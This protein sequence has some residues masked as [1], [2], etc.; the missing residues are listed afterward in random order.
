MNLIKETVSTLF[1]V[2]AI[3]A[4]TYMFLLMIGYHPAVNLLNRIIGG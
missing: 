3:A 4:A 2:I 1:V